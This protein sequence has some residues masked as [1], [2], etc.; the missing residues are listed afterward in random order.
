[1]RVNFLLTLLVILLSLTACGKVANS[2]NSVNIAVQ[3]HESS[4]EGVYRMVL[5][6]AGPEVEKASGAGIIKIDEEKIAVNLKMINLPKRTKLYQFINTAG[7]CPKKE[8]DTNQDGIIDLQESQKVAGEI[9]IPLDSE[10]TN[11][12]EASGEMPVSDS[13]GFYAYSEEAQWDVFVKDLRSAINETPTSLN[14]LKLSTRSVLILKDITTG[15]DL[16]PQGG[17][18]MACGKI[19]K[20]QE[21]E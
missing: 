17:M 14:Y 12:A 10:L 19:V 18:L 20:I 13:Q 3:K 4:P 5:T 11:Q 15:E 21:E 9:L 8:H 16:R 1:M 6:S 2:P 7:E